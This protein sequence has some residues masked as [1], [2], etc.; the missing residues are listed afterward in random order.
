MTDY[1]NGLP[2]V[3]MPDAVALV[4]DYL[5]P[6]LAGVQAGG[7]TVTV[8]LDTTLPDN[9]DGVLPFVEVTRLGG[10]TAIEYVTEHPSLDLACYA[11][12]KA[13]AHDVAQLAR[14]YLHTMR[15]ATLPGVRVYDLT[16]TSLA[17]V[18]DP[19]NYLPRF[20]L[21][22]ALLVRPA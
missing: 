9:L 13:T 17:D 1:V 14:A 5:R 10:G 19:T 22:V 18:P 16:D 11:A 21:T 6:L 8:T 7:A 3:V 2:L 12:D 4:I 20:L 15:G